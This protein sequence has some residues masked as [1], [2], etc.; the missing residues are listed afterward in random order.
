MLKRYCL[1]LLCFL[2]AGCL[3]PEP[4]VGI[5]PP[6]LSATECSL[7]AEAFEL[8]QVL[9]GKSVRDI[10]V[11]C[12]GG[13]RQIAKASQMKYQKIQADTPFPDNVV[14]GGGDQ[15]EVFRR[16]ILRG[17]PPSVAESISQTEAFANASDVIA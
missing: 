11:G 16:L 2:L 7:Y 10:L 9:T 17:T 3:Q 12:D 6:T 4:T 14:R 13:G 8:T 1:I 5:A 15:K